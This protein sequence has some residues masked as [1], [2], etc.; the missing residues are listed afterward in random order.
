MIHDV[1]FE[2]FCHLFLVKLPKHG[3]YWFQWFTVSRFITLEG[4]N[5]Y[6]YQFE[7]FF[8]RGS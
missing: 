5:F 4:K 3:K 7:G 8:F 1:S 2:V 6:P